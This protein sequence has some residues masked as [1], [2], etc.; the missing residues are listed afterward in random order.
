MYSTYVI[1]LLSVWTLRFVDVKTKT[2]FL[3]KVVYSNLLFLTLPCV[4]R[5]GFHDCKRYNVVYDAII[6]EIKH[7][8]LSV[9]NHVGNCKAQDRYGLFQVMLTGSTRSQVQGYVIKKA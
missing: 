8:E 5:A 7:L 2:V 4:Y 6:S 3:C 9:L 1:Q